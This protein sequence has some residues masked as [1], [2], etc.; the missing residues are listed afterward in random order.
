MPR[1]LVAAAEPS[2]GSAVPIRQRALPVLLPIDSAV[3]NA[4]A[5]WAAGDLR[6]IN[7]HVKLLLRRA[8]TDARPHAQTT[9]TLRRRGRSAKSRPS[10][11]K[12]Y[13][14]TVVDGSSLAQPQRHQGDTA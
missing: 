13:H 1:R 3:H 2:S 6:S 11:P 12:A 4:L 9:P 5:R 8:F 14:L 10:P 7:T